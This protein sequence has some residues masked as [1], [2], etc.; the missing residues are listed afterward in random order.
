MWTLPSHWRAGVE[1]LGVP[2]C[3]CLHA[4]NARSHC[5]LF[6]IHEAVALP[7]S[8]PSLERGASA[9]FHLHSTLLWPHL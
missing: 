9:G 8:S 6:I 7:A 1:R 4:M 3:D 2:V 5:G